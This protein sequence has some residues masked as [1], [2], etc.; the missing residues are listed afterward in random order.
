VDSVDSCDKLPKH[1]TF[2]ATSRRNVQQIDSNKLDVWTG[3]NKSM[4]TCCMCNK[5]HVWKG[6]NAVYILTVNLTDFL[7]PIQPARKLF[8]FPQTPRSTIA[9]W[10]H[11]PTTSSYASACQDTIF[12]TIR[13]G[14]LTASV[15]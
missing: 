10:G 2:C 9:G 15:H 11:M 4:S 1:A 14:T 12:P 6:S 7:T 8:K 13:T 3:P 5:L